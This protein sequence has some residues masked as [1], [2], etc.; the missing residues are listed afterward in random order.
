MTREERKKKSRHA[1]VQHREQDQS[2]PPPDRV[3][4]LIYSVLLCVSYNLLFVRKAGGTLRSRSWGPLQAE[5]GPP[6]FCWNVLCLCGV[7]RF[8]FWMYIMRAICDSPVSQ[9]A[10]NEINRD[11]NTKKKSGP[12]QRRLWRRI[13]HIYSAA[14]R[15][16]LPTIC[17]PKQGNPQQ[18]TNDTTSLIYHVVSV[19]VCAPANGAATKQ[20]IIVDT[21]ATINNWLGTSPVLRNSYFRWGSNPDPRPTVIR[22][23]SSFHIGNRVERGI[24]L[25][26]P[27]FCFFSALRR[28]VRYKKQRSL[29][30]PSIVT[31][32]LSAV[33]ATTA[34]KIHVFPWGP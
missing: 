3:L 24:I 6:S 29:L 4:L 22:F 26:F 7:T 13:I 11:R 30:G 2:S 19:C 12:R 18:R 10:G 20:L 17:M 31:L 33:F 23:F 34:G 5:M 32:P 27:V 21:R 1:H 15:Q 16:H 25:P 28:S 14:V 8:H 9:S